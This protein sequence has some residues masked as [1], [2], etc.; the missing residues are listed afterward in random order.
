MTASDNFAHFHHN[1]KFICRV[2]PYRYALPHAILRL[3]LAGRDLTEYLVK[4]LTERGYQFN[5]TAEREIVRDIK[6]KLCYVA[7]DYEQVRFSAVC[8]SRKKRK[9]LIF[10]FILLNKYSPIS[11]FSL[12]AETVVHAKFREKPSVWHFREKYQLFWAGA[13]HG[14]RQQCS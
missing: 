14:G 10:I 4:L 12:L 5:T 8:F 13:G 3:D 1:E 11:N 9:K 2:N 7:L 6:E